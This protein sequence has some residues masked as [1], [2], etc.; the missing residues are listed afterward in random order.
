MP[1]IWPSAVSFFQLFLSVPLPPPPPLSLSPSILSF[2]LQFL[3]TRYMR[4][5]SLRLLKRPGSVTW[6][7][8]A[9][10]SMCEETTRPR[11]CRHFLPPTDRSPTDLLAG[12]PAS[13][14]RNEYILCAFLYVAFCTARVSQKRRR[15]RRRRAIPSDVATKR[16]TINRL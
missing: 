16:E 15:S 10:S 14:Q 2:A 5:I 12:L 1:R 9:R 8:A 11:I 4:A 13:Q 7:A 6:M 3:L